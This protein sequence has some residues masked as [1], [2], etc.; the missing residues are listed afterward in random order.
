MRFR[1]ERRRRLLWLKRYRRL[2]RLCALA[3]AG[4]LLT[5][6]VA[7]AMADDGAGA[8]DAGGA[9]DTNGSGKAFYDGMPA[10]GHRGMSPTLNGPA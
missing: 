4:V 6:G 10:Y 7:G 2:L 1:V 3:V 8:S 9:D 5:I